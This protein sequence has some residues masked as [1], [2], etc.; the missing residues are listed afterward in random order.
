MIGVP[1][2]QT[3]WTM[4]TKDLLKIYLG[5][6]FMSHVDDDFVE[7]DSDGDPDDEDTYETADNTEAGIAVTTTSEVH[8]DSHASA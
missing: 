2:S 3:M 4:V 8:R 6:K 7:H 1:L 5:E